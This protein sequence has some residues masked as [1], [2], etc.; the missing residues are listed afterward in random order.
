MKKINS[1][2]AIATL[3]IAFLT[4]AS[5]QTATA[6]ATAS[7]TIVTPITIAKVTDMVFGNV[8][9]LASLGTVV[10][11]P[12]SAAARSTTGTVTIAAANAGSPTAAKFTVSG[13]GTYAYTITLPS[14]ASLTG[15]GTAMTV[16]TFTTSIGTDLTLG[17]LSGGTQT[18]YVGATLHVGG[19]QTA[20]AYTTTT[21]FSVT[22]A[23]N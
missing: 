11:E 1:I 4:T 12:T 7:A 8:A 9:V 15:P 10:M 3:S 14:S 20:G 6:T 17:A 18:V 5:A 19:S 21:P 22:V 13:E 23:Y 2:I 16:D